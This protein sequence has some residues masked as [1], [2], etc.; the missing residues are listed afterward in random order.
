MD[1]I[2]NNVKITFLN[3]NMYTI[4]QNNRLKNN[5]MYHIDMEKIVINKIYKFKCQMIM[6]IDLNVK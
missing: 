4:C 2:I 1:L 5:F 3:V 6:F